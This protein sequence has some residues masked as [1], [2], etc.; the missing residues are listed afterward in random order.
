MNTNNTI[1]HRAESSHSSSHDQ[2]REIMEAVARAGKVPGMSVAVASPDRLLYAD[3]VGYADLAGRPSTVDDQYPWFSMTK[4]ATAT[5]AMRMHA[6]GI[7][8]VDAP[9]GTY[10]PN[11]RPRQARPAHDPRTP[12][13][14]SGARQPSSGP[15]G[16]PRDQPEDPALLAA[17]HHQARAPDAPCPPSAAYTNIGYLLAGEV[18][19]SAGGSTVEAA[20]AT[21]AGSARHGQTGYDYRPNA[22]AAVGYVRAPRTVV[23]LLRGLLPSGIVGARVQGHTLCIPSWSA[24]PPTAASSA[25]SPTLQGWQRPTPPTRGP[26]PRPHPH[27]PRRDAHHHRAGKPFDHGIGW[28]RK[29]TDA[30]RTPTFVEHYGTGVGYWNAMRIYPNSDSRSSR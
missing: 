22:P 4:I 3:A 29:T 10:L 14:H 12:Y 30:T 16:P 25:P 28:F 11:Y 23:P 13:P 5:T 7:L 20:S 8:D 15:V 2:A 18:I 26:P 6:E 24:E 1:P 17:D 9:I 27:R 21:C 19:A